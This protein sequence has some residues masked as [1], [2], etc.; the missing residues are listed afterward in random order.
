MPKIEAKFS[1]NYDRQGTGEPMILIPFLSADH[2]CYAFQVPEFSKHFECISL[3]LRGT[4]ETDDPGVDYST[5]TLA[6]DIVDF[7]DALG[8]QR[9]HIF[10]LSLATGVGLWLGAKYPQRVRSLSLHG[11]W[12]KTD[13]HLGTIIRSWQVM[14]KALGNV[15]DVAI[16]GIFPWCLTP[17][18]YA[19]RPEY[20]ETLQAFVRSRPAQSVESFLQQTRA[21]LSHD[22]E[23]Q[24]SRIKAPTQLTVGQYD[25]ITPLRNAEHIRRSVP[26]SEVVVFENCSHAVLFE[27]VEEFNRRVLEF[28]KGRAAATAA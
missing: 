19:T 10:G 1:V 26:N 13:L 5:E 17:Q 6:D 23:A 3:D 2:A 8:I 15:H 12:T 28:L 27:N 4:G 16:N 25:Q 7:M 11:P 14:G 18:L 21:V 20:I 24:L 22:V 9:A